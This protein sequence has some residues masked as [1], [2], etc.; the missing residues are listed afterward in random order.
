[1]T[2]VLNY[3]TPALASLV[4]LI[5][6]LLPQPALA[7]DVEVSCTGS[8]CTIQGTTPLFSSA[9]KWV[10]GQLQTKVI[11]VTNNG[12]NSQSVAVRATNAAAEGG[13]ENVFHLSVIKIDDGGLLWSGSLG[14]FYDSQEI[15]LGA[16]V[17]SSSQEYRFALS[18]SRN[19]GNQFQSKKTSFDLLVGFLQTQVTPTPTPSDGGGGG[20]SFSTPSAPS[21]GERPP[22]SAPILVS[23][24][25]TG[26]NQVSLVWTTAADPVTYYLVAFGT[27]PGVMQFGNTNIGGQGTTSFT[28]SGLSGGVTYYFRVRAGNTCAPGSFSNEL[29]ATPGGP[30]LTTLPLGFAPGV[31][32]VQRQEPVEPTP[33]ISAPTPVEEPDGNV[34]GT[35]TGEN[36][37]WW[38][39]ILPVLVLVILSVYYR[40]LKEQKTLPSWWWLP[41]P[42]LVV[43]AH[44]LDQLVA[45]RFFTP[46]PFCDYTWLL[47]LVAAAIPT[48]LF[49]RG[50]QQVQ[51]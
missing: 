28:I 46:S 47:A 13:L 49:V 7:A 40:R 32:G 14:N 44:L 23:A 3:K 15:S 41:A 50:R 37:C 39:L 6:I 8:G 43:I 19:A 51:T 10:P 11:K 29:S 21:C 17:P 45:H 35:T 27:T 38:W 9:T 30:T 4:L 36:V 26:Q 34:L 48:F 31:L 1:M 22:G 42:T 25:V 16:L 33:T 2:I 12:Q 5:G 20:G 24:T 18:M